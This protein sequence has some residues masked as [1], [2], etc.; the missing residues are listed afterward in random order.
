M[1]CRFRDKYPQIKR[2]QY[3]RDKYNNNWSLAFVEASYFSQRHFIE[4]GSFE[5]HADNAKLKI[6]YKYGK[7]NNTHS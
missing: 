5:D 3:N 7:L 2:I 1:Y 4:F 6:E